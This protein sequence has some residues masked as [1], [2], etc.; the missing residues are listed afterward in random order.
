MKGP[1]RETLLM[2]GIVRTTDDQKK[3]GTCGE[4]KI[5]ENQN[6][7]CITIAPHTPASETIATLKEDNKDK[8]GRKITVRD[9]N[10]RHLKWDRPRDVSS[11][12]MGQGK[13]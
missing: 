10:A 3:G 6:I 8:G 12:E 9:M 4:D 11:Y 5:D 1:R 13:R 7:A 2:N